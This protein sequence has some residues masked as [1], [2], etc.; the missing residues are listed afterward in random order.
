L[1]TN[2]SEAEK[3]LREL[4][5]SVDIARV[6]VGTRGQPHNTSAYLKLTPLSGADDYAV[7]WTPGDRWFSL[8]VNGGYSLDVFGEDYEEPEVR[9]ILERFLR[10]ATAYIEG[11]WSRERTRFLH[12]V[13]VVVETDDGPVRLRR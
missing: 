7:V 9:E 6:E 2:V 4:A 13:H 8:E 12:V 11:R 1:E 5:A 3:L 10:I